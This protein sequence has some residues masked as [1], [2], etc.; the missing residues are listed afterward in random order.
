MPGSSATGR[1]GAADFEQQKT[2][3]QRKLA[4]ELRDVAAGRYE[5]AVAAYNTLVSDIDKKLK[6]LGG[7]QDAR[8]KLLLGATA[9]LEQLIAAGGGAK[10][11]AD[12]TLVANHKTAATPPTTRG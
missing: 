9:G 4:L 2:D 12:R 8:K 3:A 6:D 1:C 7:K 11:G 10:G 5:G